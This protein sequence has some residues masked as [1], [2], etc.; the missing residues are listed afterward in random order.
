MPAVILKIAK[1]CTE[2]QKQ[3]LAI[4]LSNLCA[5]DI[6]KPVEH[7]M[8]LVEDEVA[9]YLGNEAKNAAFVEVR[10]IGGLDN[11]VN[12]AITS[13]ICAL[14]QESLDIEPTSVYIN[15]TN[16]DRAFWGSNGKT[17]A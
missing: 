10:S 15:F 5:E 17:Y 6:G 9:I 8:A 14:L 3:D 7:M 16:M 1:K 4:Q 13:D 2:E 12:T 11:D